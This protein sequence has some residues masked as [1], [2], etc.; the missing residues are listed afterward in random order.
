MK[1]PFT[2]FE[3]RKASKAETSR[4]T[5]WSYTGAHPIL[6]SRKKPMLLSTVYRCVDLI[7]DSVAVLPLKTYQ[8]DEEGIQATS[9]IYAVEYG[10]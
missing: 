1:I 2:N 8:I 5:A 7:S 6:S 10:T 9:G 4:L 3:I